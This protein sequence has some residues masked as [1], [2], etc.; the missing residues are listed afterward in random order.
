MSNEIKTNHTS[1]KLVLLTMHFPK[2][3]ILWC[4]SPS[5][6]AEIFEEMKSGC[7]QPDSATAMS[8]KTDQ[9]IKDD[10]FKYNPILWVNLKTVLNIL[11]K[12]ISNHIIY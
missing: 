2:L 8:I 11:N 4:S 7:P 5:E 1:S 12:D 9:V 3:R 10:D 6:T